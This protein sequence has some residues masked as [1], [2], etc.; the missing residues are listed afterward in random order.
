MFFVTVA[1]LEYSTSEILNFNLMGYYLQAHTGELLKIKSTFSIVAL[2]GLICLLNIAI[3]LM[4]N[5]RMLQM[6]MCVYNILLLIGLIGILLF[7][8]YSISDNPSVNF[9]LPFVFP[10][11]AAILHFLAF[12]CIR[13]DEYTVQALNRLR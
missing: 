9:R 7:T 5:N 11:V 1:V 12:R 13:K 6:R 10:I 3:I 8:L 2:G 4:Y